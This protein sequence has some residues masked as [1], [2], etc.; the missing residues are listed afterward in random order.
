MFQTDFSVLINITALVE[1][2]NVKTFGRQEFE[3]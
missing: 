3:P 2:P 1:D